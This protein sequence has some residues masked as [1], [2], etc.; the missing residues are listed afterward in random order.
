MLELLEEERRPDFLE[1]ERHMRRVLVEAFGLVGSID[2]TKVPPAPEID[3]P[4]PQ[5]RKVTGA[6][7]P[8]RCDSG[9][10][11]PVADR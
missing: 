9:S 8:E 1:Y 5:G 10:I 6:R 2:K 4:T 11:E 3:C 7:G